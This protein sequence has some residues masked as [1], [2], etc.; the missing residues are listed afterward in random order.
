MKNC[1]IYQPCGLGDILW[2][3]PIVD[4]LI[5]LNYVV[6]FPV[7]DLYYEMLTNQLQKNNLIWVRE[8]ELFPLKEHYGKSN[9]YENETELYIPIS[10]ANYMLPNCSNM[11][12]KYYLTST[13]LTNWHKN[14]KIKRNTDRENL[15]FDLYNLQ[16]NEKYCL[17]NENYGTPPS[18][19]TRK[20]NV[21]TDYKK[22]YLSYELNKKNNFNIFD[23]IGLIENASEIHTI[24]TAVCYLVDMYSKSE[25]LFMYEKRLDNE[26]NTYYKGDNRV[27]RNPNWTYYCY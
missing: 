9:F 2:L 10:Y 27:Y 8:T 7:V 19:K 16:K 5:N 23:C 25:N 3:Q 17:I 13:P 12:S 14:I 22:I 4:K 18:Y 21:E 26:A 6:Y 11:M 20:L 1:L 24:E 15:I